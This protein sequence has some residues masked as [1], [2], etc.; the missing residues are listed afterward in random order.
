M[1]ETDLVDWFIP[2]V[3][4]LAGGEWFIAQVSACRLFHIAYP[5]APEMLK[6]ELRTIFSQLCQDDM[7]MVR[8]ILYAAKEDP[9]I[10]EEAQAMLLL[11]RN[12]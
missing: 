4:R 9:S 2:L 3:K 10:V 7:P 5:S 11:K 8:R 6:A 1:R 12:S